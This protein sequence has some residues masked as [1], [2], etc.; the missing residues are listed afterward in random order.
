M[1]PLSKIA[2]HSSVMFGV[3]VL[4]VW[5]FFMDLY[6]TA[7]VLNEFVQ[8]LIYLYRNLGQFCTA[9][10]YILGNS[11]LRWIHF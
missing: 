5:P 3:L 11:A 1:V 2:E 8:D 10:H 6:Q 7:Q 4:I 9:T